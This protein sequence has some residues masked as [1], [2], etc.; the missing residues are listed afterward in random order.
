MSTT[1][2][3][4]S[5]RISERLVAVARFAMARPGTVLTCVGLVTVACLVLSA[6]FLRVNMDNKNTLLAEHLE[7]QQVARD[8]E[9]HFPVLD[10]ALIVVVEGPS[11]DDARDG[12]QALAVQLLAAPSVARD[13]FA[14]D[15]HPFFERNAL[16]YRSVDEL[17]DFADEL[18]RVQPLVASLSQQPDLAHFSSLIAEAFEAAEGGPAPAELGPVLDHFGEATRA[19]YAEAPLIISW[20]EIL[21]RNTGFETTTRS[22]LVVDP[23]LDFD[24]LLP[25][26]HAIAEIRRLAAEEGLTPEAGYRVRITGYPALN[27]EEMRGLVFDVGIAG[28]F[29]F[30]MVLVVMTVAFRSARLMA[31]SA[32]TLVTGLL[33]TAG[34][35]AVVIGK[36][37]IVSIAFAVLFIGL[38]VDFAIHMGMHYAARLRAGDDHEA[39]FV[40]AAGGVGPTLMLCAASTAI[41]FFSFIPTDY[42][43]VGELGMISGTGMLVILVLSL[44]LLPALLQTGLRPLTAPPEP[45]G[46]WSLQRRLPRP[47]LVLAIAFVVTAAALVP[48]IQVRFDSNVVKMRDPDTESVQTWNDLLESGIGSPWYIDVLTPDAETAQREAL[49]IAALPEVE[50]TL[51]LQDYVPADQDEKLDILADLQ[52]VFDAPSGEPI[53]PGAPVDEQIRAIERLH[54]ALDPGVVRAANVELGPS[55]ALLRDRLG[56]FL[57]RLGGDEDPQATLASLEHSLLGTFPEQIDRLRDALEA[58]SIV[59]ADLPP[60][61]RARMLAEDG[62]ARLQVFAKAD[63]EDQRALVAFVDA[64]RSVDPKA[65]GLPVNIVEFGRATS[66]SL[67]QALGLAF[68][69]IS[70]LLLVMWRR[71]GDTALALLPL[72]AAGLWTV[73][74]MS[75]LGIAFNFVNVVVLPLLLGMGID[76]G[77]HLVRRARDPLE[78]GRSL[79]ETTTGQAVFFSAFTTVASFGSLATAGHA[80]IASLGEVLI[81]GMLLTMA[82]NLIVLPAWIEQRRVANAPAASAQEARRRA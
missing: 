13:V 12:A 27:D 79:A 31:A 75:L 69:C 24:A 35:A 64:V 63:L 52:F 17:E 61:L 25:A 80:G 57:A 22:S 60:R 74:L 51:T 10:D 2:S 30:A 5:G 15:S 81:L 56:T 68:G 47:S 76:S 1:P 73:A 45:V 72:A 4:W 9:A 58:E 28:L 55:A 8:F 59:L 23:V 44:T 29:S 43:G 38:G 77:V 18:Y 40:S 70:V 71:P 34:F 46:P 3:G 65:T 39:A 54:A 21:L 19:V 53:V 26:S 33:W 78:D 36:L 16:L 20:Q 62:S 11:A 66:R 7:F 6:L 37:N 49:E 32:V 42:K 67:Q 48:A 82:A 50:S 41:G 14:A